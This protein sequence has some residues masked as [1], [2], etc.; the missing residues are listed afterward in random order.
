MKEERHELLD[1]K[2]SYHDSRRIETKL[3]VELTAEVKNTYRVETYFFVPRALNINPS[4]YGKTSFYNSIQT[5]IRFKTPQMS[6]DKIANPEAEVSPLR[7]IK[8]LFAAM[9]GGDNSAQ[10]VNAAVDELKLL[11]CVSRAA[12][13]DTVKLLMEQADAMRRSG[14]RGA[15]LDSLRE[16][17]ALLVSNLHKLIDEVHA[18]RISITDPACPPRVRDT[19]AF[20]DEFFSITISDYLSLL[21][22]NLRQDHALASDLAALDSQ[23]C[24]LIAGQSEYRA[25]MG[26]LSVLAKDKP[27]QAYIYRRGVLKK[28]VFTALYLQIETT[29]W[30]GWL[31]FLFGMAAGIAMLFAALVMVFAQNRYATNSM[32]F[33]IILVVSYIFKDRIKDWFKIWFSKNWTQWMADR[34]TNILDPRTGHK[35]GYFKEA[36]SFVPENGV[37]EEIRRRRNKDNITSVDEEGKPERIMRYEKEVVLFPARVAKSHERR[38]DLNDIFR[39]SVSPFLQQADDPGVECLYLDSHANKLEPLV[40]SKL[41]HVNVV[42][43]Y[44]SRNLAGVRHPFFFSFIVYLPSH[45]ARNRNRNRNRNRHRNRDR[46]R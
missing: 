3:D 10:T 46:I 11:G 30:E 12:V 15:R 40:C 28:F 14:A 34:K 36:F 25:S 1:A 42:F 43:K 32:Q 45:R 2:I 9:L 17:G 4:T 31:Q 44:I 29:E 38:K 8:Q 39:F 20:V 18:M 13:R 33:V 16:R 41:Y 22:E 7:R 19:F 26:Y 35:I 23:I 6:L 24:G 21:L 27:N 5:H 37:P